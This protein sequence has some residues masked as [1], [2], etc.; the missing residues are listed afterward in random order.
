VRK[1]TLVL[2]VSLG[3]ILA[4]R[5][6]FS[7]SASPNTKS[8]AAGNA[9]AANGTAG[10]AVSDNYFGMTV[11]LHSTPWPS[12]P[13]GGLRLLGTNTKW[14]DINTASGVYDWTV[15]DQW[16]A[17][18]QPQH[19][20]VIYTITATPAWAATD[21]H[22]PCNHW[23]GACSPPSDLNNDGTGTDKIFKDFITAIANRAGSKIT[24]WEIWNEPNIPSGGSGNSS[25]GSWNGTQAQLVRMAQDAR[26]IVLKINP[27]AKFLTPSPNP[28]N[29]NGASGWMDG[30]LK[31]GGG[32]YADIITFHGY[33][34]IVP[35]AV[36]P[37]VTGM[38]GVM[39]K[40]GQSN[41]PLWDTEASWGAKAD[42]PDLE[43]RAAF[44]AR[45]YLL[46]WPLGVSHFYWFGWDYL[47]SGTLW[48]ATKAHGCTT[49]G[50]GGFLCPSGVAYGQVAAWLIG[51]T[52]T[53]ACS[54][55]GSVW[56]C[57]LTRSGGYQAQI[58]WDASKSC[59]NGRC[60]TSNYQV[61]SKYTK[62]V[63]LDGNEQTIVG[64]SV[65]IGAKPILLKN[66]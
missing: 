36:I 3:L 59:S 31:A 10:T 44:V 2:A 56:T 51:A 38:T 62:M 16:L 65:A 20:D 40:Y 28:G 50:S 17:Y 12:V 54:A 47:N 37:I 27:K 39:A 14:G 1:S 21:S 26:T 5:S 53:A 35:E 55:K 15:L 63:D 48:E 8:S 57:G 30:Y 34:G 4:T 43:Q 46:Q 42:F 32:Q 41:K 7:E 22:L 61:A 58:V 24:H 29:G 11:A 66:Q 52:A 64:T 25:Y 19:V 9:T 45:M 13:I 49:A 60:T 6:G 33:C 23:S 18:A